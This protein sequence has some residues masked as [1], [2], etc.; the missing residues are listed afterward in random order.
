MRSK[1]GRPPTAR[2]YPL[3]R[4]ATGWQS[5]G[6]SNLFSVHGVHPSPGVDCT[7]PFREE[8]TPCPSPSPVAGAVPWSRLTS[9]LGLALGA[10]TVGTGP[11]QSAAPTPDCTP[12]SG[13]PTKGD[14]VTAL[15][16]TSGTTPQ[17][18]TGKVLGVLQDGIAPDLDMVMVKINAPD[19]ATMDGSTASTASGRACPARRSTP[20]TA[21]SSARSP[22][23]C[24]GA[25]PGSPA[26]RR[27]R[28]WTTT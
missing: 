17:Q 7:P 8:E 13:T 19:P 27:S 26:S 5:G 28:T 4:A 24:P 9:A 20:R 16:V 15:S 21:R 1:P 23:A 12:Y 22:T 2:A 18:F 3:R 14:A 6:G 10:A 25:R 11:A